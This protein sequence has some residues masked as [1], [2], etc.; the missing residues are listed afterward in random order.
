MLGLRPRAARRLAAAL[1]MLLA[2]SAAAGKAAFD[3]SAL[4]TR[5]TVLD[6]GLTVL[7]LEDHVTPTVSFQ[8]WVRVEQ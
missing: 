5:T 3:D 2:T 6:N 1:G 4:R 7:T 8:M